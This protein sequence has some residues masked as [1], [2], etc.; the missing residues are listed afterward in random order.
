MYFPLPSWLL[1][2]N[3]FISLPRNI[4]NPD[5]HPRFQ[6]QALPVLEERQL[7]VPD[8]GAPPSAFAQVSSEAP[9]L[10]TYFLPSPSAKPIPITKQ[11]QVETSC[12]AQATLCPLSTLET[13]SA[14]STL[15]ATP[16]YRNMSMASTAPC[17]TLYSPTQT[18]VCATVLKGLATQVTISNCE[19]DVTFST[20]Y[21]Y[22]LETPAP[23]ATFNGTYNASVPAIPTPTVRTL[24][25]YLF[26]P[27]EAFTA[28]P[29]PT[30]IDRKI[31]TTFSNGTLDCVIEYEEWHVE[32]VTMTT[33]KTIHIDTTTTFPGPSKLIIWT[34]H[35]DITATETEYSLSTSVIMKYSFETDST[36]IGARENRTTTT[37][38]PVSITKTVLLNNDPRSTFMKN[39]TTTVYRG[40]SR[41]TLK[42]SEESSILGK[43]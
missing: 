42:E 10:L 28:G 34:I 16:R 33:T 39:M 15:M 13:L 8:M 14:S 2:L 4:S 36:S 31:C 40:T 25:T 37:D 24:T 29:A 9:I 30:D 20:E 1:A 11:F 21:G 18:T 5:P 22:V 17:Q 12:V 38:P 32:V 3:P 7:V 43:P 35:T 19:Q 26:A 23:N 41:T 6:H 27:W